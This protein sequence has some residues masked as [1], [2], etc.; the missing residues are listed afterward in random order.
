MRVARVASVVAFGVAALA[1]AARGQT[2]PDVV[3]LLKPFAKTADLS[4]QTPNKVRAMLTANIRIK[5]PD[6]KKNLD[7]LDE[8]ARHYVSKLTQEKYYNPGSESGE[9][10]PRPQT[11]NLDS[12]FNEV[13]NF[14]LKPTTPADVAKMSVDNADY[15]KELGAA[16]DK[17]LAALLKA[18]P[19]ALVR[20]NAARML[21]VV[22]V[23]GAPAHAKTIAGLIADPKTPPEVLI[24][25]YDAAANY[26]AA[27]DPYAVG[28][29]DATRHSGD[30]ADVIALVQALEKHVVFDAAAP[31]GPV[32]DKVSG[33]PAPAADA[34]P[35][36]PASPG[37][38][39]ARP[40]TP[41]QVKV[42]RFYR[43]HAVRALSKVRFDVLGGKGNLPEARPAFTLARVAAGDAAISP[44]PSAA[45]FG[46]AV[47]GLCGMGLNLSPAMNVDVMADAMAAGVAGFAAPR[48]ANPL[49]K[50]LPWRVAATRLSAAFAGWKAGAKNNPRAFASLAL[51][52]SLADKATAAVLAPLELADNKGT[53]DVEAV[54][55]WMQQNPPKTPNRQ[56]FNDSQAFRL[57]P[58]PQ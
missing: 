50:S 41:D 52:S 44:P 21:A 19:P 33:V 10:V 46:D 29:V 57:N 47:V 38:L 12:V 34:P 22:A 1:L 28:R 3:A 16:L 49:D 8:F 25:A 17:H 30:P 35:D 31:N 56:L 5:G 42:V 6:E 18:G 15:I 2:P 11:E 54:R 14:L 9:L 55:A 32:A 7:A 13:R 39:E 40:L 26:L 24:H 58:R 43:R 51:I 53:P 45:E 20:V 4:P 23:S 36:A 48:V 27:Y 37:R